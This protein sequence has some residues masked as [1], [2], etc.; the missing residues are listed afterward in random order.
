MWSILISQSLSLCEIATALRHQFD[1]CC[2][3]YY[4]HRAAQGNKQL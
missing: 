2:H 1:E 4:A 3:G